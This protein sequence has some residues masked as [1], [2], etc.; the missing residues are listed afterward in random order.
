MMGPVI[1]PISIE[2]YLADP[3]GLAA[4]PASVQGLVFVK[5]IELDGT[6]DGGPLSID[7]YTNGISAADLRRVTVATS[8]KVIAS[9][10]TDTTIAVPAAYVTTPFS[11][12]LGGFV[13]PS[14][15]IRVAIAGAPTGVGLSWSGGS[16]P[17]QV[18]YR[19]L[20]DSPWQNL[21]STSA[22][23]V[24]VPTTNSSSLFRVTSN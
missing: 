18:Q 16:A 23:N 2:V 9:P 14:S 7:I 6:F 5:H 17:F 11:A 21:L 24:T 3:T 1:E 4:T 10:A 19:L 20:L 12:T 15:P 22:T 13:P 8:Y